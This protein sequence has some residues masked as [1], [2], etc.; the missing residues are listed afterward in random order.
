MVSRYRPSDLRSVVCFF[1]TELIRAKKRAWKTK[2]YVLQKLV[3]EK[4]NAGWQFSTKK[5]EKIRKICRSDLRAFALRNYSEGFKT[6]TKNPF[7]LA[8]VLKDN[9]QSWKIV[10]VRKMN[11]WPR[12]ETSKKTMKF[13]GQSFSWGHYPPTYQP[14]VHNLHNLLPSHRSAP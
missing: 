5:Q 3:T 13:W 14:A 12:S 10:R 4:R 2:E 11:S 1:S 6:K 8:A 7:R 9:A